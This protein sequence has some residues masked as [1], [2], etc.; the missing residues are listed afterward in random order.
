MAPV[1]R[2]T[3]L[4]GL[5][6]D[7]RRTGAASR[8]Q[9]RRN[10]LAAADEL[11]RER[12]YTATTVAA[13][14]DRAGV[15]LQTLYL[16]WGSKRALLRAAGAAAAVGAETPMTTGQWRTTIRNRLTDETGADPDAPAYLHAVA[17]MFVGVARR[18]AAFRQMQ[19]E[20]SATEP[21]I[22]SDTQATLTERRATMTD[23]AATIPTRG[24]RPALTPEEVADTLWA[25]ASPEVY[26][27]LTTQAGYTPDAVRTWLA[28]TLVDT[29][30]ERDTGQQPTARG[31]APADL[32]P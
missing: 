29:L 19:R 32:V 3:D 20:A 11:F 10:L 24:L 18:S 8:E 13:I 6:A 22:A 31:P 26:D 23:V 30:C 15:S 16:A 7:R 4:G 28:R 1:E 25:I 5:H 21:E 2:R 12:G 14:A 27:L 9:T 17:D